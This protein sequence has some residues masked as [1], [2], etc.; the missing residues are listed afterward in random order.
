LSVENKGLNLNGEDWSVE[1]EFFIFEVEGFCVEGERERVGVEG[2]GAIAVVLDFG[3]WI[4][5]FGGDR[6]KIQNPKPKI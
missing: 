3:F 6:S 4:L 5:D 2:W 1:D